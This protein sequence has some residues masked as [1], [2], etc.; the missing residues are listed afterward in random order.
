MIWPLRSVRV[1]AIVND[2]ARKPVR[3]NSPVQIPSDGPIRRNACTSKGHRHSADSGLPLIGTIARPSRCGR[4]ESA[5]A[6]PF[7]RGRTQLGSHS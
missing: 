7:S 6:H 2:P 3:S 5:D 1:R 4:S